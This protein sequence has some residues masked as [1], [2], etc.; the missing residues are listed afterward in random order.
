MPQSSAESFR[1]F[2]QA[3]KLD[4]VLASWLSNMTGFRNIT[5]HQYQDLESAIIHYILKEG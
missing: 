4:S 1:L 5:I 3:G 2:Q